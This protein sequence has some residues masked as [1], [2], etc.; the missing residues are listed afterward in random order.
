ML[1]IL[2]GASAI[3]VFFRGIFVK[4]RYFIVSALGI[5]LALS[6][7]AAQEIPGLNAAAIEKRA[8][9]GRAAMSDFVDKI[10]A[11]ANQEDTNAKQVADAATKA[12]ENAP[13]VVRKASV[14]GVD[15]GGAFAGQQGSVGEGG[16]SF[17]AFA[18]T[19][20]PEESLKR[21]IADVSKAGGVVVFRGMLPDG[22]KTFLAQLQRVVSNGDEARV[23][24]DPRLFR[25]FGV[26]EVPS[27]IAV[28]KPFDLCDSL[29]CVSQPTPFDKISG[30]VTAQ[31]ALQ[32]FV[33]GRGPGAGVAGVALKNL[34]H[35]E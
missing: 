23:I 28:S 29:D 32:T 18:S 1:V 4:K 3:A 19:S 34:V 22:S 2:F 16:A 13:D 21:M 9:D 30:N 8:Q 25:A 35:Q 6:A 5:C 7:A 26:Q 31:Y 27:Y 10:L 33:D 20:M 14:G 12:F 15:L 24:V 17:F 11:R